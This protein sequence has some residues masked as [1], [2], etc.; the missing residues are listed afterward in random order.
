MTTT[1]KNNQLNVTYNNVLNNNALRT[2][3]ET[4]YIPSLP[5][6]PFPI[7]FSGTFDYEDPDYTG[8]LA[9]MIFQLILIFDAKPSLSPLSIMVHSYSNLEFINSSIIINLEPEQ[10]I[11]YETTKSIVN[12]IRDSWYNTLNIRVIPNTNTLIFNISETF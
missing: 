9:S 7:H 1:T 12:N 10:T 3:I 6:F 8:Y 2:A 4:Q 5:Q 11:D